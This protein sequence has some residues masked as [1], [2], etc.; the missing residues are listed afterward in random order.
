MTKPP[1]TTNGRTPQGPTELLSGL[2]R[3]VAERVPAETEIP[4]ARDARQAAIDK[5]AQQAQKQWADDYRTKRQTLESEYQQTQQRLQSQH[6]SELAAAERQFAATHDELLRRF[7]EAAETAARTR[8]DARWEVMTIFEAS[9]DGP[10]RAVDELELQLEA[11]W[12]RMHDAQQQAVT[13]LKRRHQWR[14]YPDP[15]AARVPLAENPVE[16]YE[17][18]AD[19]AQYQLQL[20]TAQAVPRMF[21]GLQP[22]WLCLLIWILVVVPSVL[23]L[24]VPNW[25]AWTAASVGITALVATVGGLW[26]FQVAKQQSRQAYLDLRAFVLVSEQTRPKILEMARR[27]AQEKFQTLV[28]QRDADL[29]QADAA[30]ARQEAEIQ[31]QRLVE[32]DRVERAHQ[33]E[34]ARLNQRRDRDLR[35][36]E[37]KYPELLQRLDETFRKEAERLEAAGKRAQA[38]ADELHQRR[39]QEMAQRWWRG[40]EQFQTSVDQMNRQCSRLF[41]AWGITDWNEWEPVS[42]VLPRIRL[43]Q[44]QVDL[45]RIPGGIPKD[46]S[47]RPRQTEFGL[48][49]LLP[50]PEKSLLLLKTSGT[51]RTAAVTL[52]Q[53]IMLRML[54]SLPPGKV[55]FTILDPVGLGENF[56]AFMHLADFDEQLVASRIWT[57]ASHIPHRLGDLTQHMENVLQVYLRNEFE[58]IQDYN[59]FAGEMA[60]AYR[61]LVIANFP[62]NF[63]EEAVRRLMSIVSSGAR[64]GVFTLMSMDMAVEPPQNFSLTDLEPYALTLNWKEGRFVGRHPEY[65]EMVLAPEK[66]PAAEKF[67]EIVRAIGR[68]VPEADRIEVPFEHIAPTDGQLWTADSRGGIDV[69]LGRAGALKLQHLR[70]GKG[71][72]QHVLISGKTGSGKSTLLHILITNAALRYSPDEIEFYLI[73]FKK[74]VEFK[75]Y[76]TG[77]LPHARVIAI[78]SEREFG[79][80]VLERLD[81]EL[82]ER[83][84]RFRKAGVQDVH[85]FRDANPGVRLPRI[86]LIIDEFQELFVEEDRIAQG[87]ALL[88]DRLVRQ[89]RAFGIHVLLGS[90]T[91][92]GAYSLARSTLGQMAVRIALQCS[93]ADAHLILSEDNTAARLLT[94]PG[95]A[96]YNDA[97]GLFE[98][99][100][101]FQ[102]S[103]LND[104]ERDG[105]LE[106]IAE[107]AQSRGV[108]TPPPTVFEGNVAANLAENKLLAEA[109]TTPAP[110]E[111]RRVLRAWLGAAVAI[112]EA[113]A[114]SFARQSGANLL[115]VGQQE[116]EALGMLAS[117]A[118]SLSVQEPTTAEGAARFWIFDGTRP[119]APEAGYWNQVAQALRHET[120]VLSPA[121]AAAALGPITE[122]LERRE[123]GGLDREPALYLI[124]YSLAR[125]RELRKAEDDFGFSSFGE[126]KAANPAK[127]FSRILRDGPALGIH[128]LL[129]C[130]TLN[131]VSRWLDRQALRDL[132]MR[133]ALQMNATDSASLIDSPA[134]SKLGVHRAIL[135]H[136]GQGWQE[137]F[138]PYGPPPVE[139]LARLPKPE[140]LG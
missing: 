76:A 70:L 40:L 108:V 78:E 118:I 22:F 91:L 96:I 18:L 104:H 43:G 102:I 128:T 99:N 65:G 4:A 106:R 55:R 109:I 57:D 133:V 37:Q 135:Y 95:E 83:G 33:G 41:P 26:F 89:G 117:A 52:L 75:A 111:S 125:F 138:R 82:R 93:E 2:I 81:A 130:D 14:S 10:S 136:E 60:E 61:V 62:A 42:E 31:Q 48:P 107:F 45:G 114:A 90:Q 12:Q 35:Q 17:A 53:T 100:H 3:L 86:L 51:G 47:L 67:T 11:R 21:E 16:T 85:G 129:W 66:P 32:M 137:K 105:F 124:V 30:F 49:A 8:Q 92:G 71:T 77:G 28:R 72:S 54:T 110:P 25:P 74:G 122:E 80:S 101:P 79:L 84:D 44:F 19:Q 63:S 7:E 103:W 39:A 13:L 69:P 38:E 36:V 20:L 64:C 9:K 134:A 68:K 119:D 1:E 73:D 34:L 127:Q 23:L 46:E 97:N 24:G 87:A 121:Q 113:T 6:Q 140:N 126:E 15:E 5:Q 98:G 50:F 112:K 59:A 116:E 94:R 132:E 120:A 27:Q 58:S 131:N 29:E 56:S 88:L 115:I 139:W 123:Q